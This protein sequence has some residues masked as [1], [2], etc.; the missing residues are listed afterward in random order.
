MRIDWMD[1][2]SSPTDEECV[3]VSRTEPYVERMALEAARMQNALNQYFGDFIEGTSIKFEAHWNP[4]CFGRYTSMRVYY[5]A[6]KPEELAMVLLIEEYWP[7][8]WN[9]AEMTRFS[10]ESMEVKDY[11]SQEEHERAMDEAEKNSW[12]EPFD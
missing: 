3:Y 1:F 8:S 5:D 4:H 11:I 7:R 2:E 12:F 10:I 9:E 6:D